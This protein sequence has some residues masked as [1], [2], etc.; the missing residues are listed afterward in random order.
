MP[1]DVT[2]EMPLVSAASAKR[3]VT[4][5]HPPAALV[6]CVPG[7]KEVRAEGGKE[8]HATRHVTAA[9]CVHLSALWGIF[10]EQLELASAIPEKTKL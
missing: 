9:A 2:R 10:R 1:R 5:G 3:C 4:N 8:G 6:L 7:A